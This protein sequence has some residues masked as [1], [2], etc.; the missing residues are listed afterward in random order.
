MDHKPLIV[1]VASALAL[2]GVLTLS[3]RWPEKYTFRR[4]DSVAK[5]DVQITRIRNTPRAEA[6]QDTPIHAGSILGGGP[7]LLR[8]M[9]PRLPAAARRRGIVGPVILEVAIDAGG[10][11]SPM[12]IIRGD[13]A[14][15]SLAE[16]AVK[17]WTYEPFT[18]EGHAMSIVITVAVSFRD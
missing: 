3:K 16:D 13:S 2:L 1:I 5:G 4:S 10:N 11:V 9:T 18:F 7:K 6:P 8:K 15:N 14:L 17:R 12:R